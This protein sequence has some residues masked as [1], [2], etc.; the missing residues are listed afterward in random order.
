MTFAL[1]IAEQDESTTLGLILCAKAEDAVR[2]PRAG[3]PTPVQPSPLPPA[4]LQYRGFQTVAVR[5]AQGVQGPP[6]V[7]RA[8]LNVVRPPVLNIGMAGVVCS[9]A[10]D[11]ARSRDKSYMTLTMWRMSQVHRGHP[12]RT[13]PVRFASYAGPSY[14]HRS[15]RSGRD[16]A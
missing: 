13:D 12:M 8:C 16:R 7:T 14:S 11:S 1:T 9:L 15:P 5:S 2:R 3:D 6:G 10:Q 4:H